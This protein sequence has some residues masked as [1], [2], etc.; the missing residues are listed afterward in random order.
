MDILQE[1]ASYFCKDSTAKKPLVAVADYGNKKDYFY[2]NGNKYN[3]YFAKDS[4]ICVLADED[5][6]S[7]SECLLGTLL[8]YGAITYGDICLIERGGVAKTYGKGIMQTTYY[9]DVIKKDALKLTTA[10][11]LW[12]KTNTCIHGRGVLSSDGTKV[13]VENYQED[14]EIFSALGVL[15]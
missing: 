7:A 3:E 14:G 15:F 12:P 1:I 5:T 8:D 13:V 2:A 9:L 6:A 11:V 4:R 10:R